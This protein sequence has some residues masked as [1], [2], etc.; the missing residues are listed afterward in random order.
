M[1]TAYMETDYIKL[2]SSY[3]GRKIE[4]RYITEKYYDIEISESFKYE[5]ILKDFNSPME[6]RFTSRL[7]E[8]WLE[9]PVLFGAFEENK[10]IGILELSHEKWN[11]RLRISNIH[12]ESDYRKL[13]I[14][15]KLMDIAIQNCREIEARGIVLETQSCNYPAISFY[16]KCGFE[17]IGFDLTHYSD[18]DVKK[19]EFRMEFYL[20]VK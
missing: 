12:I 10:L 6:K 1:E 14:G 9:N 2:D 19:K 18:D 4:F 5:F 7:L 13:G 17:L 15:S 11:N 8:D 16:R 20:E 3:K